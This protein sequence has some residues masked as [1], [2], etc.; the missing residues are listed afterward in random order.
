MWLDILAG[1]NTAMVFCVSQWEIVKS[2]LRTWLGPEP[3]DWILLENGDILPSHIPVPAFYAPCALL[4]SVEQN[5]IIPYD[6]K[7]PNG[8]LKRLPWL[9]VL[10]T[11]EHQT[12]DF[13]DWVA[14][15][16]CS[17]PPTLLQLV[18]LA[19]L[20]QGKYLRKKNATISVISNTGDEDVYEFVGTT[21]LIKRS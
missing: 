1:C 8:R 13:S 15:V 20:A 4:Y 12:V 2:V 21:E 18:R 14:E 3:H 11:S 9:H 5:S 19:S 17:T 7:E 10:Y 6:S 16:R